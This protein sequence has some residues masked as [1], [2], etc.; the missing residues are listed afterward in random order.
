MAD[1]KFGAPSV[2]GGVD[3]GKFKKLA[4]RVEETLTS[5]CLR[6]APKQID[7]NLVLACPYNRLGASP[8]VPHIHHGILKSIQKHS[9]D[10][11]RPAIW[12]LHR[13]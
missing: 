8:N 3:Q 4:Q 13:V 2:A 6:A 5:M 12:N 9:Y 10:R 1:S 7:P 11:T